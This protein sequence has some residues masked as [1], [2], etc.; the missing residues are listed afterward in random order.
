MDPNILFN[1]QLVLPSL[2]EVSF[3]WAIFT[4][5]LDDHD[6]NCA[7][8]QVFE[9]QFRVQ[10]QPLFLDCWPLT[11]AQVGFRSV[12]GSLVRN[13]GSGDDP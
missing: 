13:S 10:I 1:V 11:L 8:I 5:E 9:P 3:N 7:S 12:Y 6:L 4:I 2:H